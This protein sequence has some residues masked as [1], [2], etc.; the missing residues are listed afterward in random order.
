MFKNKL[1]TLGFLT[2]LSLT[3][4]AFA[5]DL[6]SVNDA[7]A[8]LLAKF[9]N[10]NSQVKMVLSKAAVNDTRAVELAAKV[11]V[12]K[13][14]SITSANLDVDADYSY[15][16]QAGALPVLNAE[17]KL[18]T[19]GLTKI[20]LNYG[21]DQDDINKI[22]NDLEDEAQDI[23]ASL[24]ETYGPA[25]SYGLIT[26]KN[27]LD[28]NG[29][30]LSTRI[31]LTV[32]IDTKKLPEGVRIDDVD[33]LSARFQI[34]IDMK[35]G[36]KAS[37]NVVFNP[38]QRSFKADEVG[39]KEIIEGLLAEDEQKIAEVSQMAEYLNGFLEGAVGK[40]EE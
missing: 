33:Y 35:T 18:A 24:R 20:L 28:E 19:P 39:L 3:V 11:H 38:E 4:T 25:F 26:G 17:I 14:G 8:A 29:N 5:V 9:N 27:K 16:D 13:K 12:T 1:N 40:T 30:F 2:A 15:P 36:V 10:S 34:A 7:I 22:F 6:T 37:A 23:I 32:A 31:A 21:F